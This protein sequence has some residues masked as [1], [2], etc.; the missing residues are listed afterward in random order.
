MIVPGG[1]LSE[2]GSRWVSSRPGFL[3]HVNLLSHLFRGR[4]LTMLIK[5][6]T[7]GRLSFFADHAALTDRRAFRRCLAPLRK[8]EWVVYTK[9]PFAGPK[10]VLRY[11]SR[12]TTASPSPIVV[13][14]PP[15]ITASLSA[16]RI[17]ASTN[18][19]DGGR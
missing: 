6:R 10:Q 15:T 11:L 14:S 13:W 7:Q 8:I 9:N 19:N 12:Y 17:T 18:P 1:G 2:D 3:V 16:G 4:F 5:A